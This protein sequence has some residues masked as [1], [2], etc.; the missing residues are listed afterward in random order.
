MAENENEQNKAL[1]NREGDAKPSTDAWAETPQQVDGGDLGLGELNEPVEQHKPVAKVPGRGGDPWAKVPQN[2]DGGEPVDEEVLNY[3]PAERH[4]DK[5]AWDE[6]PQH[7][8]GGELDTEEYLKPR[9]KA[10]REQVQG[11]DA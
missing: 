6:K 9:D 5:H 4:L 3:G 1:D 10:H 11:E 2:V 8:D 7:V